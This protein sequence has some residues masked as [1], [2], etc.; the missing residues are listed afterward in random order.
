MGRK[1]GK[2]KAERDRLTALWKDKKKK[3]KDER[4]NPK[5][6]TDVNNTSTT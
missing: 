1:N 4:L 5:Q 6:E 2:R 3:A